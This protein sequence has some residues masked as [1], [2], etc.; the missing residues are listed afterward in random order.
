VKGRRGR[1]SKKLLDN[2]KGKKKG[3]LEI[4]GKKQVTSILLIVALNVT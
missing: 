4:E 3:I 2:L 1:R